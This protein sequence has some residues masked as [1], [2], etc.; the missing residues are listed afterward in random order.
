MGLEIEDL[1]GRRK[2]FLELEYRSLTIQ[3]LREFL[4][5]L[6]DT[7]SVVL[8]WNLAVYLYPLFVS[9]WTLEFLKCEST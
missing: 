1:K 8:F 3:W 6:V 9:I 2:T 7:K 4:I 5:T